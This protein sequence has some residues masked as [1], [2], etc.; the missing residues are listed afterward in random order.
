MAVLVQILVALLIAGFV[1]WLGRELIKL[2]PADFP[3]HGVLNLLVTA[4]AVGIIIFL[5]IIPLLQLIP[6]SVHLPSLTGR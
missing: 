3:F 5:V 1:L 4:L 2:L 6:G